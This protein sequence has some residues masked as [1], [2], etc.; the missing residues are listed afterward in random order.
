M[1]F[2]SF[3]FIQTNHQEDLRKIRNIKEEIKF[4]EL[5]NNKW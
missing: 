2:P 1:F 4:F 5:H 3:N